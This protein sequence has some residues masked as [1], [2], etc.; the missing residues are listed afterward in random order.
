MSPDFTVRLTD[1]ARDALRLTA[2]RRS[3]FIEEQSIPE[4]LEWDDADLA[5]VHALA[6]TGAGEA[7]GCGRLIADGHI[8]RL[9]VLPGWRRRGVGA[10]L[11]ASLV[12][13]ARLHGHRRVALN[14]QVH[15]MA[16]YA[17]YGFEAEGPTFAE[18]GIPHR[19]MVRALG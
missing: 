8:G 14:A 19:A 12:E 5:C 4:S 18:A 10:A 16:F 2:V 9:A 11:L 17:R 1:W 7:I 15:A 6:C 3:V 13:A